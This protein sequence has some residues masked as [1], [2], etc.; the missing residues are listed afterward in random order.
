MP[1]PSISIS[2]GSITNVRHTPTPRRPMPLLA[3]A[4]TIPVL[5]TALAVPA[6]ALVIEHPQA[7]DVYAVLGAI[8]ASLISLIEARYKGRDFRPALTNFIASALAGVC[9]PKI[10]FLF[11]VQL[12]TLTHE[13][14]I[15]RAWE[16]WAAAGFVCGLNGWLVIHSASATLKGWLTKNTTDTNE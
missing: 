8:L 16:A 6:T 2:A 9:A 13:S 4:L 1:P 7:A 14:V 15:V 12:G 10:G 3:A 11:L 5:A